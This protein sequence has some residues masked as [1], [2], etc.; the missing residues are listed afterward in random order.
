MYGKKHSYQELFNPTLE[1]ARIRENRSSGGVGQQTID[2]NTARQVKGVG[3]AR[4]PR[5]G[6]KAGSA[7][8]TKS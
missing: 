1:T 4:R 7:T 6:T 8:S 3:N 2:P 5:K